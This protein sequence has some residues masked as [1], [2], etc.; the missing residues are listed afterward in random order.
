M[1]HHAIIADL[2]RIA[3]DL[4]H[5]PSRDEYRQL[6]QIS[7]CH[8]ERIFKTYG[9][10]VI[11]AGLQ[12][13]KPGTKRKR[14]SS[15]DVFGADVVAVRESI[16]KHLTPAPRIGRRILAIGDT[17]FPWASEDTLTALYA[18]VDSLPEDEKPDVIVQVGDLHDMYSWKKFPGSMNLYNPKEEI[19]LAYKMASEMWATLKRLAP[20]AECHQILGNHD[21]RALKRVLEQFPEGEVFFSIER[22]YQFEGVRT[23]MDPRVPLDLGDCLVI[24]GHRSRSVDHWLDLPGKNIIHGHDHKVTITYRKFGG[25]TK[26]IMG[27]GFAGDPK[28]KVF[29]YTPLSTLDMMNS[30]GWAD[31]HG[32]RAVVI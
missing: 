28:A 10:A 20:G 3:S 16:G 24:H 4:G 8:I 2:K 26:W 12:P 11:A 14:L 1:D 15:E 17:H 31:Q 27:V 7:A 9:A 19:E 22:F 6:S 29:S 13:K 23:H 25:I 18:F 32:P 5:T 21:V 30:I